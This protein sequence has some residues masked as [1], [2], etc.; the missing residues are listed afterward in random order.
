MN[1]NRLKSDKI[2]P[3]Q[4]PSSTCATSVTM[5]LERSA[6]I[7][8]SA[9]F[10]TFHTPLR[11]QSHPKDFGALHPGA[12]PANPGGAASA[13]R[14]AGPGE[15]VGLRPASK[16]VFPHAAVS[17]AVETRARLVYLHASVMFDHFICSAIVPAQPCSAMLKAQFR[18]N[19]HS[20]T[21]PL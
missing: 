18:P 3:L 9:G 14:A 11:L 5:P 2:S 12:D 7:W 10:C 17:I 15:H 6:L 21:E 4:L 1:R 16:R 19:V 13:L 8:C 20:G